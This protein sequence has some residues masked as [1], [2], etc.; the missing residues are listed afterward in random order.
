MTTPLSA[1]STAVLQRGY[2][3]TG[4]T[5][6]QLWIAA[7]GIGGSM[8]SRDVEG[9]TSGAKA[10]TPAEHDV[11]AAALNDHFVE[12]NQDHPIPSWQDLPRTE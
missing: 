12:R 11:L 1:E 8:D 4:W 7:M 10:A 6:E 2:G 9:I 5:V 3:L